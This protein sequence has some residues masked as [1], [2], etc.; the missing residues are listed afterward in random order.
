MCGICGYVETYPDLAQDPSLLSSMTDIMRHRGP[1]EV[2]YYA[3]ECAHL[4][5]RR[6]SVIDL[7]SGQQPV[8]N[9]DGNIQVVFNGEIYNFKD[10]RRALLAKGHRFQSNCDSEV[11]AHAYEEYGYHCVDHFNGMFALAIWDRSRRRLYLARDR[12]GIKPL[13]YWFDEGRLVF[14]SELKAIMLHPSVPATVDPTSVDQFLTLE[15]I[16]RSRSILKDVFKLE[17]GHYLTFEQGRLEKVEYWDLQPRDHPGDERRSAETLL[18][19]MTDAVGLRLISD[20]PLGAFLSGGIDSS[21]IVALMSRAQKD[22]VRTFSI[23]FDDQTYN[24]LPWARLVAKEFQTESY[25]KTLSPDILGLAIKLGRH[26]DEPIADFSIFPTYL[27]SELAR[28]Q[29]TVALSGDGGD[30]IFGGYETYR[31]ERLSRY[32]NLLPALLR[33]DVVPWAMT[34][35]RPRAAKKGL[36]N[37]T[38]RFVEGAAMPNHWQHMR[39]MQFMRDKDRGDL[40]RQDLFE[41]ID[42]D[43]LAREVR[44]LFGRVSAYEPLA[45]QQYLDIKTYLP[46]NILT[47]VDRMSMAVSLEARVPML[48]HRLVELAWSLP[49]HWKLTAATSKV[50]L[51]KAMSGLLPTEVLTKPKE[52]FSIPMKLWLGGPLRGLMHDLLH[53]DRIKLRGYFDPV[54]TERWKSEHVSGQRN[55]SHRLWALMVLEMWM[56]NNLSPQRA[57]DQM[58]IE[59]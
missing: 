32:Y 14:G 3:D 37:K 40:Y 59:L 38:K 9:E 45:Q 47:K 50:I 4:G 6:L 2:G 19:L 28:S 29:V 55:H 39:W 49:E 43:E 21:S 1:D 35:V 34:R 12:I 7:E 24:E 27:V 48:D 36:V 58:V 31:A 20:V 23:G 11:I 52:G 13:Y 41:S 54:C 46:D 44:D 10:I 56:Q 57:E 8:S 22:K 42:R 26:L 17:P 18:E 16:P 15:Y 25:E 30:E 53:P 33:N 5:V 51:R